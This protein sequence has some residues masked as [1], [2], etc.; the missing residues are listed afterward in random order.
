[1]IVVGKF[2]LSGPSGAIL[3]GDELYVA[4][5]SNDLVHVYLAA[6]AGNVAPRRSLGGATTGISGC[7][8]LAVY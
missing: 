4:S 8:G 7:S 1:M 3:V 2:L 5:Y 6:A